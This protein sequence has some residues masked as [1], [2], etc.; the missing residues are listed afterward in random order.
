MD[1]T[2][3]DAVLAGMVDKL[4]SIE[5]DRWS[6]WQRY[7]H[8]KAQAQPDGSLVIP[9]ELVRQWNSQMNKS[10]AELSEKEKDSDR[11][12]VQKYLPIIAA[13]LKQNI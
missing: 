10:F 8:G 5:H 4:S 7:M 11:E 13:V 1:A 6:H 3:I 9:S 12:Q 2:K